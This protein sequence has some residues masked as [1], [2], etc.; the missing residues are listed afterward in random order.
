MASNKCPLSRDGKASDEM[1]SL[2]PDV[3]LDSL[4]ACQPYCPGGMEV[5]YYCSDGGMVYPVFFSLELF[6]LSKQA[7]DGAEAGTQHL[8]GLV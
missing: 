2:S 5:D 4:V 1:S 6:C 7:F 8:N 3:A